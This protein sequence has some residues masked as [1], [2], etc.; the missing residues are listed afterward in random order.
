MGRAEERSQT[1][2]GPARTEVEVEV[3]D[4]AAGRGRAL[5][6]PSRRRGLGNGGWGQ[7][8]GG[9]GGGGVREGQA[10]AVQVRRCGGAG[11]E[12]GQ[13]D[14]IVIYLRATVGAAEVISRPYS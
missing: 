5:P 2:A 13:R 14:G 4:G 11:D 8:D 7:G 6:N 10:T 3:R 12:I 1:L 9:G